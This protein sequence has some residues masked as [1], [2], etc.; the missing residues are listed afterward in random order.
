MKCVC[1]RDTW[2]LAIKITALALAFADNQHTVV[3]SKAQLVSPAHFIALELKTVVMLCTNILHL[4][5]VRV[6]PIC[7]SHCISR[8]SVSH[9]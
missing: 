4:I 3:R 6:P 8:K 1:A 2:F 9:P 5:V 7:T